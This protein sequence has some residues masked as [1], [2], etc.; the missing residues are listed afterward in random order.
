MKAAIRS[1]T[2]W[3]KQRTR[4]PSAIFPYTEISAAMTGPKIP[5]PRKAAGFLPRTRIY[6]SSHPKTSRSS[7]SHRRTSSS[8]ARSS[9]TRSP[10]SVLRGP[11]SP[12]NRGAGSRDGCLSCSGGAS[13]QT[14]HVSVSM[15]VYRAVVGGICSCLGSAD[16][17][18][19]W[20]WGISGRGRAALKGSPPLPRCLLIGPLRRRAATT[21]E[22]VVVEVVLLAAAGRLPLL[23][24]CHSCEIHETFLG[25]AWQL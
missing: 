22:A 8:A 23:V 10:S 5:S 6:S 19:R 9:L 2:S 11:A 20:S 15:G 21:L 14:D 24:A 4:S 1:R 13:R 3:R 12:G 17:R 25:T 7:P 16:T 18:L